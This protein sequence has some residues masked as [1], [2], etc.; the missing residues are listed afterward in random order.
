MVFGVSIFL[1]SEDFFFSVIGFLGIVFFFSLVLLVADFFFTMPL[2]FDFSVTFFLVDEAVSVTFFLGLMT[3][4]ASFLVFA[5]VD[6]VFFE[7]VRVSDLGFTVFSTFF[8]V[9][10]FASSDFGFYSFFLSAFPSESEY[11]IADV[12]ISFAVIFISR[13]IVPSLPILSSV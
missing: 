13:I 5:D 12:S 3:S 4:V 10:C 8:G 11:G 7:A 1:D 6:V 2:A 9:L